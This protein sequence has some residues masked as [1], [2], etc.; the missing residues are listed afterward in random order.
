M[1]LIQNYKVESIKSSETY[2]WLLN[3]HY[4][5][6]IPNIMYSFGLYK[7]DSLVGVACFGTPANN[8]N[9]QLGS[10][11][12]IELVRLVSDDN[13]EKNS[14]SFFLSRCFKFLPK[15]L[16]LISYSD[17]GKNHH[18]YVYQSTNWIYTGKGGGVDFYVNEE[19]K[20]I[21]SRIMSDYRLKWPHKTRSQIAEELHWK[22]VKG[23]YKHRYYQFIGSKK[24]RKR[25]KKELLNKYSIKEYPKGDNVKYD[26]SYQPSEQK[27]LF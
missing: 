6:T 21:H 14:L 22:M 9:N 26:A 8:H 10:F 20:E 25:W 16:S 18:G 15:P 27:S 11:K 3:K 13:L 24:Q 19:G 17:E 4:A 5:K 7:N 2:E 12:Q 1:G 23:T